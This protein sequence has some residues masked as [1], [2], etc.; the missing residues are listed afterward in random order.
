MGV[1]GSSSDLAPGTNEL[2]LGPAMCGGADLC[3]PL[4]TIYAAGQGGTV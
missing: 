2:G 4:C 3:W 1:S